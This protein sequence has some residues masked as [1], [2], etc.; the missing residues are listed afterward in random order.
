MSPVTP[1]EVGQATAPLALLLVCGYLGST[2]AAADLEAWWVRPLSLLPP[3]APMMM[4][5][6]VAGDAVPT[7]EVLGALVL[8]HAA[9]AVLIV[10]GA[11]L[12]RR[13][14]PHRRHPHAPARGAD[15][16]GA[17]RPPRPLAVGARPGAGRGRG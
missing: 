16:A 9:A 6:R 15:G 17:P 3:F 14:H 13:H 7:G 4:P 10:L 1:H 8:T 12:P 5:M 2:F 11:R